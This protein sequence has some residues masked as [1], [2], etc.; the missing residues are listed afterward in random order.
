MSRWKQTETVNVEVTLYLDVEI[1][2]SVI[3][4]PKYGA[5]ADGNRGTPVTWTDEIKIL[6]MEEVKKQAIEQLTE[7][8]DEV[9]DEATSNCDLYDKGDQ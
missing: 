3:Q 7:Q 5:D 8:I 6:N 9:V 1:E 2:M 4:D